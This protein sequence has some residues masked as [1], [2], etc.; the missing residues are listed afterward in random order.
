MDLALL[1]QGIEGIEGLECMY[2]RSVSG[3]A[4]APSVGTVKIATIV[5]AEVDDTHRRLRSF[6]LKVSLSWSLG[7]WTQRITVTTPA[8]PRY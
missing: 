2:Q 4:A 1:P 5:N 3:G 6:T 8:W 7:N